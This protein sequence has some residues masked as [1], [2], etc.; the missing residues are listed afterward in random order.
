MKSNIKIRTLTEISI[1]TALLCICSWITI[2]AVIPFTLQ[3]LSIFFVLSLLGGKK[4]IAAISLYTLMGIIGIPVFSGFKSGIGHLFNYTGGF[5][6]G[7][8][9]C[10]VVYL[11]FESFANKGKLQQYI[12]LFCGLLVCYLIGT[13][14]FIFISTINNTNYNFWYVITVCVLPYIIPDIL[15]LLLAVFLANKLK[16]IIERS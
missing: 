5:I 11:V 15:K 4:G 8:I 6:I 10:G 2:P 12:I 13:I 1:C 7:F 16:P 14:W 9:F 3:T